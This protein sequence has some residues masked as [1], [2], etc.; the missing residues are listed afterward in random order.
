[1]KTLILFVLSFAALT[2]HAEDRLT[3]K[4][5]FEEHCAECHRASNYEGG[6]KN[7]LAETIGELKYGHRKHGKKTIT[8]DNEQI[9]AV[10]LYMT[11]GR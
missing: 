11:T 4:A 3:G 9:D 1:M 2:A 10:A 6:N 5:L 7:K 8:L